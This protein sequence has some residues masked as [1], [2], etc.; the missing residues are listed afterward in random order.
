MKKHNLLVGTYSD[1]GVHKLSFENGIL[2]P[3][4]SNSNFKDCSYLY[5]YNDVIF[6][7]VE[8]PDYESS[9]IVSRNRELSTINSLNVNGSSPCYICVDKY[10]SLIYIANY[11]NGS[12]SVFSLSSDNSLDKLI[13]YKTFTNHSHIHCVELSSDNNFLFI[14]DLGDN[15][16]FAYKIIFDKNSFDLEPVS[17]Y[18]F[19]NNTQPRHFVI[20][21]N[22]IFLVT[23]NSCELYHFIFSE[24]NGIKLLEKVSLLPDNMEK[25]ENYTGCAICFG[26]D[27]KL[28]YVS[29]R[30]LD[31]ICIFS[32]SPTM[33]LKEHISCYG[34]TPRDLFIIDDYLLCANQT[35]NS[36]S[37]FDI[38]KNTGELL[39]NNVFNI[40]H[41]AHIINL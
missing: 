6:N 40:E 17:Q 14:T 30:G 33:K 12:F 31:N 26:K 38:N 8:G 15:K 25:L 10:R 7:V 35:S 4:T 2:T 21:N 16:L 22:N 9:L 23:E 24:A 37:I 3:I 5:K 32:I 11:T 18:D 1:C 13:F 27:K 19:K 39:L 20:D 36:I 41:P 34:N 29:I 28:L